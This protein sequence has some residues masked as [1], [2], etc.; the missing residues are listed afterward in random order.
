MESTRGRRPRTRTA[1]LLKRAAAIG[2]VAFLLGGFALLLTRPASTEATVGQEGMRLADRTRVCMLQDTVQAQT[3]LE[4]EH[5]GKQYYLCCGGS[6]WRRLRP[7]QNGTAL[8]WIR[9]LR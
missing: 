7:M 9:S 4:Y 3:G 5:Q 2:V 1:K 8:R 6:A